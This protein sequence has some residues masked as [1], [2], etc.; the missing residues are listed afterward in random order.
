MT[1]LSRTAVAPVAAHVQEG[2][3][4]PATV[5]AQDH[6]LLA[7]VGVEEVVGV[8]RQRLVADHQP[9]PPEHL[10]T[11]MSLVAGYIQNPIRPVS[12]SPTAQ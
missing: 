7:L 5:A 1:L 9:S 2:T 10:R 6:R 8:G 3:Q 11:R 12:D 4:V